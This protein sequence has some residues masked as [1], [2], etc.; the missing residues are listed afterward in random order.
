MVEMRAGFGR[1]RK[2]YGLERGTVPASRTAC[3]E[4]PASD[5]QSSTR[6]SRD[7]GQRTLERTKTT[8]NVFSRGR[9]L[10]E[11]ESYPLEM[12]AEFGLRLSILGVDTV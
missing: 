9:N 4:A 8:N 10:P 7:T 3:P 1:P 12:P 5:D 2:T 6:A 11:P